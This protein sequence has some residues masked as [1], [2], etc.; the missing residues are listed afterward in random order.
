MP[1]HRRTCLGRRS[2]EHGRPVGQEGGGLMS[3]VQA[4]GVPMLRVLQRTAKRG[5]LLHVPGRP[6]MHAQ[7]TSGA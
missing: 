3:P 7:H 2:C 6:A 5:L 1:F 4:G